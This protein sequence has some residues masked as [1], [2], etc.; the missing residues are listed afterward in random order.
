[1]LLQVTVSHLR[2]DS[3]GLWRHEE[4]RLRL[5]GRCFVLRYLRP[6]RALDLT[7]S[8]TFLPNS[9]VHF[10]LHEAGEELWLS[11]GVAP[12]PV[13][14]VHA[15]DAS[16]HTAADVHVEKRSVSVLD[17]GRRCRSYEEG[18]DDFLRC[19]RNVVANFATDDLPCWS[20]LTR[21]HLRSR[22][23]S[24]SI[25]PCPDAASALNATSALASLLTSLGADPGRLGCPRPCSRVRYE[26]RVI[27]YH[28]S[29]LA[30]Q[31]VH[32]GPVLFLLYDS[33]DV[34]VR[35]E[36]LV[37]D[38]SRLVAAVGGSVGL[39]LGLSMLRIMHSSVEAVGDLFTR[40]AS[41]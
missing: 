4:T 22:S 5:L 9:S 19:A 39:F 1:M 35:E 21:Q 38:F 40:S 13:R 33:L 10:A 37:Y 36:A 6:V 20:P 12:T 17:D 41:D 30:F 24:S 29:T 15:F 16:Q 2:N 18:D 28:E 25:P 34:E 27:A 11:E 3:S 14:L 32:P 8:L 31:G 23:S 7:T 26:A